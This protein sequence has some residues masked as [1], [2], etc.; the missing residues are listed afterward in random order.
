LVEINPEEQ[1]KHESWKEFDLVETGLSKYRREITWKEF[2]EKANRF[3]N[4][5]SSKGLKKGNKVAILLMNCLE[6]LPIY[7]GILKIGAI[8]VPLNYRYAA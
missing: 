1:E 5:L 2:D 3:A 7:F 4:L 6:W 8:V